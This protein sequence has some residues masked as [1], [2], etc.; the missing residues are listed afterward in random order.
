MPDVFYNLFSL[1]YGF[2]MLQIYI[3]KPNV[4]TPGLNSE[5]WQ[6]LNII[7]ENEILHCAGRVPARSVQQPA[8]RSLCKA[9]LFAQLTNSLNAPRT[10]V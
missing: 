8:Y 7:R 5:R 10:V 4:Y 1:C 9:G 2:I 3:K 6:K